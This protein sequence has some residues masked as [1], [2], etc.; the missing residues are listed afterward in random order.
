MLFRISLVFLILSH[1]SC[2]SFSIYNPHPNKNI[3]LTQDPSTCLSF[4]I[5]KQWYAFYGSLSLNTLDSAVLFPSDEYAYRVTELSTVEDSIITFFLG[6]FT[7]MSR[8]TIQVDYCSLPNKVGK[9]KK[10]PQLKVEEE[11]L[12]VKK[13]SPKEEKIELKDKNEPTEVENKKNDYIASL[14]SS[15]I[16]ARELNILNKKLDRIMEKQK[17]IEKLLETEIPIETSSIVVDEDEENLV[18]YLEG[19]HKKLQK[20]EQRQSKLEEEVRELKE[21]LAN[22]QTT[23]PSLDSETLSYETKTI[24]PRELHRQAKTGILTSIYF[25]FDSTQISSFERAKLRRIV[26][27]LSHNK[28]IMIVGH[29]DWIGKVSYNKMLSIRRAEAVRREIQSLLGGLSVKLIIGKVAKPYRTRH[30]ESVASWYRRADIVLLD[31]D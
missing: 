17:S 13:E 24:G 5:Y 29:S 15:N 27:N 10:K 26:R 2:V 30:I 31:N 20:T 19:I 7:T 12:E 4:K 23:K 6:L 3:I 1:L 21:L 14:D 16:G 22:V 9:L 11:K 28:K 8:K 18:S 25:K